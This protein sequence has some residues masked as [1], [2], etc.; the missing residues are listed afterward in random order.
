MTSHQSRNQNATS[1]PACTSNLPLRSTLTVNDVSVQLSTAQSEAQHVLRHLLSQLKDPG[2][3][4]YARYSKWVDRHPRLDEFCFRCVRPQVWSYLNGRW[5][6]DAYVESSF[7][8][9][10]K[11]AVHI[12]L[13]S[14]LHTHHSTQKELGIVVAAYV[15][16]TPRP[17]FFCSPRRQRVSPSYQNKHLIVGSAL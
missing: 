8:I 2:S 7:I 1:P 14:S 3:I 4:Y 5:S 17:L 12:V 15:W 10:L 11:H 16:P 9:R 6:L 13:P